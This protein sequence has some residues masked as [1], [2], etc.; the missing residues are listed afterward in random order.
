MRLRGMALDRRAEVEVDPDKVAFQAALGKLSN[1]Q[2]RLYNKHGT[3]GGVE[4]VAYYAA[5]RR[6]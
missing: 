5:L 6:E 4:N 3:R 2:R 1:W